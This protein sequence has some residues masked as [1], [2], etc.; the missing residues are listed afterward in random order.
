MP[1]GERAD[2]RAASQRL[3]Q[4]GIFVGASAMP[5][6]GHGLRFGSQIAT[7]R[8]MGT[9]E[10][11]EIAA[12]V[13]GV[14]GGGADKAA[15]APLLE[16]LRILFDAGGK[17][18]D[19][20]PMYGSSE[21][22]VGDLL[23]ETN[24][25]AKAF[26]ATKVWTSGKDAGVQQMENSFRRMRTERMDL[27]QVHNLLDWR[28][29]LATLQRWKE[30]GRVRY[31][32]ITHYTSSALDDLCAVIDKHP[33]DFVQMAYSISVRDAERRLLPLAADK[34]VAVLV[35]RP[36]EGGGLFRSARAKPLPPWAVDVDCPTWGQFFLKFILA[37]PAVTC[38]IPG[39]SKPHHMMD[40]VAAGLGRLPGLRDCDRMAAYVQ[41]L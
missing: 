28:T 23:G 32:G 3:E 8:G 25:H 30:L 5:G 38:V 12:I 15:R 19:S 26:L 2:A 40:N 20:S 9:P 21:Q 7:R 18:I 11:D 37:H 33:V 10:M 41:G 6:A 22:V 39:T 14:L 27:M 31:I 16:V 34:G 29:H 13:A 17:T 1:L 36:F 4:A 24:G 35:N